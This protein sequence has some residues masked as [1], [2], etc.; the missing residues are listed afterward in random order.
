MRKVTEVS[1]EIMLKVLK[2]VSSGESFGL[3]G[4]AD[5]FQS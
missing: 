5:E 2:K 1:K 3:D 4:T